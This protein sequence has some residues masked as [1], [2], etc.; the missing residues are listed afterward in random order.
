V[1]KYLFR[2]FNVT[3]I[4]ISTY[5][6]G[7]ILLAS[8]VGLSAL[9]LDR[10]MQGTRNVTKGTFIWPNNTAVEQHEHWRNDAGTSNYVS[11]DA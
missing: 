4:I 11:T 7:D 9:R 5:L 6:D 3:N 2:Q 1:R 10:Q 8:T